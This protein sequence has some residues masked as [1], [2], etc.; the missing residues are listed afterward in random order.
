MANNPVSNITDSDSPENLF[1]NYDENGEVPVGAYATLAGVFSVIFALFLLTT[2]LTGRELPERVKLADLALLGVAAHKLSYIVSNASV[3]SFVRAPVT[4]L[5]EAKSPTNLD[6]EPRGDGLQKALG[7][8]LTCH[9]CLGMWASAFFSYGLV[10]FP[11]VTRFVASIFTILAISDF[12]HQNY[13]RT[14]NK[15]NE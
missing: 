4:E 3:M 14:I 5:R 15:A 11:R 1:E 13:K 2:R 8:L 6:E 7:S 9:F 10:L 12:T